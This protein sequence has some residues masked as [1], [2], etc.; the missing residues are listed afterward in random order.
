MAKTAQLFD[1]AFCTEDGEHMADFDN[2][3]TSEIR[4]KCSDFARIV[5]KEDP[6]FDKCWH[7]VIVPKAKV[8]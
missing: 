7:M 2:L 4:Q 1:V 8:G 5:R 3:T 6:K